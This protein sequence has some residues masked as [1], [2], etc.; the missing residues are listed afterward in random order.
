MRFLSVGRSASS[1]VS[2]VVES[3]ESDVRRCIVGWFELSCELDPDD[4][5]DAV[6]D[7]PE[8]AG[9]GVVEAVESAVVVS[10]EPVRRCRTGRSG[11]LEAG[12]EAVVEL[13][14]G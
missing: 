8:D 11:S 3:V 12:V 4:P 1:V 10:S 2:V 13:V 7:V 6:E 9:V 5:E 14:V